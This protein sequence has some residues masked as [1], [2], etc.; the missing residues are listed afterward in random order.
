MEKKGGLREL[1]F[2][3]PLYV[4]ESIF[5]TGYPDTPRKRAAMIVNT[6]FLHIHPARVQL[7]SLQPTYTLGLGLLSF[8]LF[9]IL[10]LTGVLLMFYY[11]PSVELA[12]GWM[13]D[14]IF[15]VPFG[16]IMRNLHRWTAH[17]MVVVVFL[18]MCRVFY[19][20]AYKPPREFNWVVGVFLL[21]L[22]L[23]SSFT[24]YLLPWDQ[25]SFWAITVATNIVSYLP[26][27]GDWIR[28]LLLGGNMVGGEALLRFYVLH[29]AVLPI[30]TTAL[31]AYHF[32]RIRKDGGLARPSGG[33]REVGTGLR[34][35]SAIKGRGRVTGPEAKNTILSFPRLIYI[36]LLVLLGLLILFLPVSFLF[37]GP[38]AQIADPEHPPN[39]A[40]A[41][42]YFLGLQELVSYSAFWGGV[43]IPSLVILGLLL[44]PYLDRDKRGVGV[45]F[46]RERRG[47]IILWTLFVLAVALLTLIGAYF[48]GPNWNFYWPWEGWPGPD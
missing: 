39:P 12:Y 27:L 28:F 14:L 35:W 26:L 2:N 5:R 21:V 37:D 3:V 17:A 31:I 44:L 38:L 8:F 4:K 40:K 42:W 46:A 47:V 19:T 18:H 1:L 32:W 15:V 7:H 23:G 30:L 22:T 20:A 16:R 29:V 34:S 13:Q 10:G 45:W 9:A 33:G 48:R 43:V 41:P 6:L 24:G 25:L 36:E 11:V